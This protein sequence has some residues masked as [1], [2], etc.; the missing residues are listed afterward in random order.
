MWVTPV[1]GLWAFVMGVDCEA[2]VD[3]G[4]GDVVEA[5]PTFQCSAV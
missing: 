2:D 4:E 3:E 1:L 5:L